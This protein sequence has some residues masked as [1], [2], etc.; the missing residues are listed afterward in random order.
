[1]HRVYRGGLNID[2]NFATN[3]GIEFKT[4]EEYFLHEAP[5]PFVR[6]FEPNDYL[7]PHSSIFTNA[8]KLHELMHL[9]PVRDLI[10]SSPDF[11]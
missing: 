8:S 1:M 7:G 4:P 3:V 2:R 5:H 11:I 9:A 10:H 6:D